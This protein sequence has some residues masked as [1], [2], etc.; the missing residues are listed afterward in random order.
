MSD[1]AFPVNQCEGCGGSLTARL[2]CSECGCEVCSNCTDAEGHCIDCAPDPE[3]ELVTCDGCG[4]EGYAGRDNM[5]TFSCKKCGD[6]ICEN[7]SSNNLCEDCEAN[8]TGVV[9]V[10]F[11]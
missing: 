2:K 8:T 4:E 11:R 1:D 7:C 9:T 10:H 6:E 5:F 3:D